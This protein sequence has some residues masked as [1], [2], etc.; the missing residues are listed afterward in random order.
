MEYREG[1]PISSGS[2]ISMRFL[3]FQIKMVVTSTN[4][5]Q[6]LYYDPNWK[7]NPNIVFD[8]TRTTS[9]WFLGKK[10]NYVAK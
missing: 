2:S 1:N 9:I 5:I 10:I 6:K 3:H 7:W 8:G 4:T